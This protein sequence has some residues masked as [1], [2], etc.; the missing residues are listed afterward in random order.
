MDKWRVDFNCDVGEGIGNEAELFP[1]ISSCNIACGGHAGDATSIR[2]VI[3]LAKTHGIKIGAH[4]SY[5]DKVNFGRKVMVITPK[6]LKCSL[7][8]Q[9]AIFYKISNELE[10]NGPHPSIHFPLAFARWK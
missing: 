2:D 1:F 8:E 5:P 6:A 4:P 7:S 10:A 9:L 3:K